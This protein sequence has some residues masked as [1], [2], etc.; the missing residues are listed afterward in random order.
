MSE[1]ILY[2]DPQKCI[3]CKRCELICSQYH[4]EK[5]QP[6]LSRI[7]VLLFEDIGLGIPTACSDCRVMVCQDVCPSGAIRGNTVGATIIEERCVGCKQCI[8]VCPFGGAGFNEGKGVALKCDLCDGDPQCVID[9]PTDAL[10]FIDIDRAVMNK[11]RD[12]IK[13]IILEKMGGQDE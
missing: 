2:I 7:R 4:E 8:F 5:Y 9:C 10:Q 11:K 1:K 3:G 13:E 6:L 12:H